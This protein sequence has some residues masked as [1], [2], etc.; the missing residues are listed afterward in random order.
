MSYCIM[1][2]SSGKSK[3]GIL[4]IGVYLGI[5]GTKKFHKESVVL[6]D[7]AGRAKAREG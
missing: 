5:L 1:R 6:Y 2:I 3:A 7:T 4:G